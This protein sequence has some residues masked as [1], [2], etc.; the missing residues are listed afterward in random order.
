VEKVPEPVKLVYPLPPEPPR[1]YYERTLTGS[2]NVEA[3]TA[4]DRFRRFATGERRTGRGFTKPFDIVARNG[5]ILVSDTVSRRVAV[6]DFPRKRYYEIGTSGIG[7]LTKPLGVAVDN[8]GHVYVCDGTAK[9]IQVY[10]ADGAYLRSIGDTKDFSRPSD[11]AVNADGSRIY[12]VDTGGVKETPHT[13]HVFDGN[14][15]Y[16]FRIGKRGN[17]EGEF[18]LPLTATV[19]PDGNL[20]V[21]DTGNFRVQV[22]SPD[23]KFLKSFGKAGRVPGTFAH[24]KG[25]SVDEAGNVYVVDTSFGNFQIFDAQGRLLLFIGNRGPTGGPGEYLLPA[26]ISVDVDGR[27][28][29]VDQFFRKVDVFR[30]ASL[31]EGAVVG[32]A[33]GA[34]LKP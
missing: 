33:P 27:I 23:G 16:L 34:A 13:V 8:V 10:D 32:L 9:R 26:G 18:N 5:R 3:D 15:S 7:R 24:P 17:K 31:P 22:F 21:V 25:I 1:F 12:V 6:L 4:T 2:G 14:G 29:V 20:Y 30:P 19:G 28:Y 11:V